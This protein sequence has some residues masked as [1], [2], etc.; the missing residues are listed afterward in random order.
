MLT[1]LKKTYK[2]LG[3]LGLCDKFLFKI[4]K[5]FLW[6]W[7][8]KRFADSGKS[9]V[10]AGTM[11]IVGGSGI[12]LGSNIVF[13]KNVRLRCDEDAELVINDDCYI[14]DNVELSS[15]D[16]V[17]I[18]KGAKIHEGCIVSGTV[19]KIG[20]LVFIS[21]YS[22][23]QGNNIDIGSESILS[24]FVYIVDN[25]HYIDPETGKITLEKGNT[26]PIIVEENVWICTGSRILRGVTLGR[27]SVIAAGSVVTHDVPERSFAANIPAKTIRKTIG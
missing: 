21:R 7:Y 16:Y 18:G 13:G 27:S 17:V 12:K 6:I 1:G 15:K 14:A 10:F 4:K 9:V 19:I 20:E 23:I 22:T 2:S 11:N 5:G 26:S 3:L 8:I 24:A 25:A